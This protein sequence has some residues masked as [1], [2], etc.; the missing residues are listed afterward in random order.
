MQVQTR[1]LSDKQIR[2]I[3]KDALLNSYS[4]SCQIFSKDKGFNRQHIDK[5]IIEYLEFIKDKKNR[6]ITI[7]FRPKVFD[8]DIEH[9]EF[10]IDTIGLPE[11]Y[12]SVIRVKKEVAERL[13]VKYGLTV[14]K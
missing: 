6:L 9:W 7:I 12:Y 3:F 8:N 5:P 1:L 2:A 10:G 14:N 11:D 13:F 4:H